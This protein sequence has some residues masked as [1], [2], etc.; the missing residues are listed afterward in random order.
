[1]PQAP[2]SSSWKNCPCIVHFSFP[3]KDIVHISETIFIVN[4]NKNEVL[5]VCKIYI[6]SKHPPPFFLLKYSLHYN[7]ILKDLYIYKKYIF[8][9][10]RC[11]HISFHNNSDLKINIKIYFKIITMI[12][13]NN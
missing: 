11:L 7:I 10:V 5:W 13:L 12:I 4:W 8:I 6:F 1:V 9:Y 2:A 3:K